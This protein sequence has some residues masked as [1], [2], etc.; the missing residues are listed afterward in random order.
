ML[1]F[2]MMATASHLIQL[3]ICDNLGGTALVQNKVTL[4]TNSTIYKVLDSTQ[5]LAQTNS[6]PYT[7]AKDDPDIT[8][9]YE[10]PASGVKKAVL[11]IVT[12]DVNTKPQFTLN[13]FSLNFVFGQPLMLTLDGEYYK[14][15][16]STKM[17]LFSFDNTKLIH[18]PTNTIFT[19][20]KV[21]G[22]N[23]Y[24][25][26]TLGQ[27]KIAAGVFGNDVIISP[28]EQGEVPAAYVKPYNLTLQ[29]EVQFT[30]ST[31]VNITDPASV[32]QLAVCQIDNP[33]DTQQVVICRN[34][35]EQFTLQK[36]VLTAKTIG[37][38]EYVFFYQYV[39]NKKRI[40]LLKIQDISRSVL[41]LS[42]NLNLA[43][44]D[45]ID[46]MIAGRR[47][48][49]R[50]NDNLYL[51]KHPLSP[52]ISLGSLTLMV[53]KGAETTSL[54]AVGSDDLAEFTGLKGEKI[55]LQRNYGTPPPPF[56]LSGRSVEEIA[57][58]DLKKDLFTS[59][60][61][62]GGVTVES[63]AFGK[64][65]AAPDDTAFYQPTFKVSSAGKNQAY[66]LSYRQP[67]V[68]EGSA[69]F[70]Y[71]TA[72]VSGSTPIKTAS[73]YQYYDLSSTAQDHPFNDAFIATITSGKE[74]ALRYK[75]SYY[76]LG[77]KGNPKAVKFYDPTQLT[78]RY[79]N[80]SQEFL[81]NVEG[82]VGKFAIP[83]GR[84]DVKVNINAGKITFSAATLQEATSTPFADFTTELTTT[85]LVNV[86]D[87]ILQLCFQQLYAS[88]PS[89]K[90]CDLNKK[91]ADAIVD[92][93]ISSTPALTIAGKK[94]ILES[95]G[96]TGSNKKVFIRSLLELK[97]GQQVSSDPATPVSWT[98]FIDDVLAKKHPVFNLSGVLYMPV[99]QGTKL[100][101]LSLAP[102]PAGTPL[103]TVKNL[104]QLTP[105]SFNGN[106]ILG[107]TILFVEQKETNQEE[108]PLTVTFSVPDYNYL[109]DNGAPLRLN[110]SEGMSE[111]KF[112]GQLNQIPFTLKIKAVSGELVQL[113]LQ[114]GNEVFLNRW[115][116]KDELR[117]LTLNGAH[118]EIKVQHVDKDKKSAT[119]TVRRI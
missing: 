71:H 74:L 56:E 8:F 40:S 101:G 114:S 99:A 27:K 84:I 31:P 58:V 34:N 2:S 117:E 73:I 38:K 78:L 85:N 111:L 69:L 54:H 61:S 75:G 1:L 32:G 62:T 97:K 46:S 65:A 14:F 11:A 16:N 24:V 45:F 20:G 57:P 102:F 108:V 107:D 94:Y 60:G 112:V 21:Q 13:S 80:G 95:N 9:L 98:K 37:G 118:F 28:L 33:A 79:L 4:C 67:L 115:F 70:Y 52:T 104:K 26:Q 81:V 90:V 106:F 3:N 51:L 86:G 22:T 39:D 18:I 88:Y 92:P 93:V 53:Y 100:E 30:F 5:L 19:P 64:L 76:L 7:D 15:T 6:K 103:Y 49:I 72:E 29:H 82:E 42:T 89:A 48:A 35:N 68:V 116:A 87:S 83:D 43:Y 55:Y 41:P 91:V 10:E 17:E 59:L 36:N 96:Q 25:F 109:P 44:N 77:H 12:Y 47:I 63:P 23:W 110:M 119:I 105:V 113:S 66:T 50:F